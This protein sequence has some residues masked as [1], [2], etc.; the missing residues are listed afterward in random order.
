MKHS[1]ARLAAAAAVLAVSALAVP[2]AFAGTARAA[3]APSFFVAAPITQCSSRPT[4]PPGTEIVAYARAAD[5][6]LVYRS[7]LVS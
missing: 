5:G 2:A 3:D 4:T 6:T 7:A 1:R